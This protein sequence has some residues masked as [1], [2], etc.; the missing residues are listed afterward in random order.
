MSIN[1][2]SGGGVKQSPKVKVKPRRAV[3]P[4]PSRHR[5]GLKTPVALEKRSV[6]QSPAQKSH[7]R[8]N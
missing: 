8:G 2:K 1:E 5:P 3:A 4:A 6:R 7:P